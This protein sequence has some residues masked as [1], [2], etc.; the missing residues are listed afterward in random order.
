VNQHALRGRANIREIR[1]EMSRAGKV[2]WQKTGDRSSEGYGNIAVK[3]PPRK[4]IMAS[5]P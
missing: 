5:N 2:K 3:K 1:E 4:G